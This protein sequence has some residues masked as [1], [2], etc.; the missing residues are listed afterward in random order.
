MEFPVVVQYLRVQDND[1]EDLKLALGDELKEV[2]Q[3]E[4]IR[5]PEASRLVQPRSNPQ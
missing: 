1:L 4:E 2:Y 3:P 5:K